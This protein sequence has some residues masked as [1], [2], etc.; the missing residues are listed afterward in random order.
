[1]KASLVVTLVSN[2]GILLS[3]ALPVMYLFFGIG[4]L[5]I[6][7]GTPGIARFLQQLFTAKNQGLG[8]GVIQSATGVS[9]LI[10]AAVIPFIAVDGQ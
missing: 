10:L 5:G 6:A 4:G 2:S 1:L 9:T 7:L 8:N 3:I